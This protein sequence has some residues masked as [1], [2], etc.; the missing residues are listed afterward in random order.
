[1]SAMLPTKA[2]QSIVGV[3]TQPRKADSDR[4]RD[5]VDLQA[6]TRTDAAL[7]ARFELFARV[8]CAASGSGMS[9]GSVTYAALSQRVAARPA[10]LALARQCRVRQ[11]I[12]NLLFAA[13]KR[14]LAQAPDA[15][16][17]PLRASRRWRAAD[18][19]TGERIRALLHDA[20]QR[21]HDP[22]AAPIRANQR[23][24]SVLPPDARV[25]HRSRRR[26]RPTAGPDRHRRRGGP[27]PAWDRY[28]YRYSDGQQCGSPRSPVVIECEVRGAPVPVPPTLPSVS[29]RVGIDLAPVN[30]ADE[31]QYRWM[32]AL[33]WPE[34]ADRQALLAAARRAWLEG[35]P[36][37]VAGDA[38]ELLPEFLD[39]T[40]DRA[41][42]CVYHCHALNQFSAVARAKFE[43]ILRRAVHRRTVYHVPSEGERIFVRRLRGDAPHTLMAAR[44]SAHGRWTDWPMG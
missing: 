5:R 10:L 14:L 42:I 8:E 2:N 1:M 38:L 11:P 34:H 36:S 37:V 35:P 30:L 28:R 33:I 44:R 6:E 15:A 24:A 19:R 29:Q 40:P 22:C 13:V 41:A 21:D 16:C 39:Q 4:D 26:R 7:A 17:Q 9:V 3:T 23:G 31:E 27:Q 32:Q 43:A 12:P 25:L 18:T 20:R